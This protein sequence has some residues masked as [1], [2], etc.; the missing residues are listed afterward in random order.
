MPYGSKTN[1][2]GDSSMAENRVSMTC[3]D[4]VPSNFQ[5][6]AAATTRSAGEPCSI[7]LVSAGI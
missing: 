1:S 3:R 2:T 5:T 6:A 7:R 4:G